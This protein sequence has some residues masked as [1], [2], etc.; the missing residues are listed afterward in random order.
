M[1]QLQFQFD[2]NLDYQRQAIAS[3]SV[4]TLNDETKVQLSDV[5]AIHVI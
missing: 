4:I 2:P 1:P 5:G 3:L